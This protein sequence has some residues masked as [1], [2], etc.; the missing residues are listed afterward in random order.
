[1]K[2]Q[3]IDATVPIPKGFR[4][5]L[6][7]EVLEIADRYLVTTHSR[8]E[9]VYTMRMGETITESDTVTYVRQ[10]IPKQEPQTS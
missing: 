2:D 8:P 9:W 5:L 4:R 10:I 3:N 7:G 1:M 6:P